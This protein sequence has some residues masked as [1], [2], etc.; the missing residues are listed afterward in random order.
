MKIVTG[1][2][3]TAWEKNQKIVGY[4]KINDEFLQHFDQIGSV[5]C[6]RDFPRPY[7]NITLLDGTVIKGVLNDV[8]LKVTFPMITAD[9]SK[10]NFEQLLISIIVQCQSVKE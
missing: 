2:V 7:F 9:D 5:R 1:I 6:R 3:K 8:A 10:V 4:F